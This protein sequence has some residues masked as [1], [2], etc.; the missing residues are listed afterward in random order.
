MKMNSERECAGC[1]GDIGFGSAAF[2]EPGGVTATSL[3]VS[4]GAVDVKNHPVSVSFNSF[5]TV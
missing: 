3:N 4:A 5:A 1:W 2:V